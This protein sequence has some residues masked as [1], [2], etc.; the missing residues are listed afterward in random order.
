MTTEFPSVTTTDYRNMPVFKLAASCLNRGYT[1]ARTGMAIDHEELSADSLTSSVGLLFDN[2]NQATMSRR[3]LGLIGPRKLRR[4]HL[5]DI[6]VSNE[7]RGA[8]PATR[9]I[10]EVYGEDN[11]RRAEQLAKELSAEHRVKIEVKLIQAAPRLE[12]KW[13]DYD[14]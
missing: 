2:P 14:Y 4:V 9:W 1:L 5:G 13:S 11:L 3:F 6:W 12:T 7:H 10:F 8:S